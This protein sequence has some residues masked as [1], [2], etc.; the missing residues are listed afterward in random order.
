MN[1]DSPL[2]LASSIGSGEETSSASSDLGFDG[3]ESLSEAGHTP[4][5]W[6]LFPIETGW[7][8]NQTGGAGYIGTLSCIS[9]RREQCEANAHLIAASPELLEALTDLMDLVQWSVSPHSPAMRRA[10][11]VLAKASGA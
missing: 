2:S 10:R 4:G 5:P 8:V 6:H 9:H 11:A 3:P 7:I 1:A